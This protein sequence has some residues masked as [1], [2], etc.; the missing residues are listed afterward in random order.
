MIRE[1]AETRI[2]KEAFI[3]AVIEDA[4]KISFN[5]LKWIVVSQEE[6]TSPPTFISMLK[7]MRQ[8]KLIFR[9]KAAKR[10]T[11]YSIDAEQFSLER[12][13]EKDFRRIFRDIK[14]RI[15]IVRQAK[16]S[17]TERAEAIIVFRILLEYVATRS[18]IQGNTFGNRKLEDLTVE[19]EDIKDKM[20]RPFR[21]SKFNDFELLTAIDNYLFSGI[22]ACLQS[23]DAMLLGKS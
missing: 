6:I 11:F 5:D 8:R 22:N 2:D 19:A 1:L 9:W 12:L 20:L 23:L 18:M 3:Y 17:A 4:G 16:L 15:N 7:E 14:R 10:S 13:T 21:K